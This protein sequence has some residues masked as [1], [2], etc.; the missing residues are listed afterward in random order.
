MEKKIIV[1][2]TEL[3]ENNKEKI[4]K[5]AGRYGYAARFFPSAK[6]AIPDAADA[7]IVYGQGTELF[8]AAKEAKWF[9]SGAAGVDFAYRG[10]KPLRT[11]L[12][13][14]NSRGSYGVTISEH[15]CMV[16]LELLR[17]QMDYEKIVKEKKWVRN[18]PVRSIRGSRITIL[19]TGD[20][21]KEA[22]IRL[23]G[24]V[25]LCITGVN[26]SGVCTEGAF[27]R[28]CTVEELEK[29]LPVTDI[30][31]MCL[32][33]TRR[34]EGLL[35]R[36]RLEMLPSH[37]VLVNVGRGS[38]VDQTALAELLTEGRLAGAALDVFE[39]EP[40]PEND[41]IWDCRNLLITPHIAGNMTLEYTVEKNVELF[42]RDLENYCE[43]RKLERLVDLEEGY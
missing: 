41:F 30:L 11:D 33:G 29:L 20:L 28:V 8:L 15:I 18:L 10:G 19:G 32:P 1:A 27:D 17:R 42:C 26:R 43:G 36:E 35:S 4:R 6:E 39:T 38:A 12:L 14:T 2:Y 16:L 21:G 22:A 31:I 7:E 24:F 23:R 5:T 34:T 40:I 13:L 3:T 37:A 9:C 25:P